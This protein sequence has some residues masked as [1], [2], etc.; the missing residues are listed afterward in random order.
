MSQFFGNHQNRLDAKRRV[1]VPA[2]FRA[3]LKGELGTIPLI[4]RPGHT[5]KCIEA[6]P[7]AA[8][9]K[10]KAKLEQYENFTSEWEA[11]ATVIYTLAFPVE[12]DREGRVMIP[13]ELGA[14]AS[15]RE[16]EGVTFM[17][18]GPIFQI[19]EP[20]AGAEFVA[21]TRAAAAPKVPA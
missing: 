21:R 15:I 12:T 11:W 5:E 20:A 7:V 9:E 3:V 8:Y 19:W 10:L 13:E 6:W 4:L 1:S 14:Y 17:G 16:N 18:R 2:A